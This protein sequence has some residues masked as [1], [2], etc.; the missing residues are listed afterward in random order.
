[1][2]RERIV[3]V[4]YITVEISTEIQFSGTLNPKGTKTA[5]VLS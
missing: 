5:C 3:V 2:Y 1:M 4:K